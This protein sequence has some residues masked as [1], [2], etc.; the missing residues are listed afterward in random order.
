MKQPRKPPSRKRMLAKRDA[1]HARAYARHARLIAALHRI[2]AKRNLIIWI[3]QSDGTDAIVDV[4]DVS[5]NGMC[6]Q[7]EADPTFTLEYAAILK[8]QGQ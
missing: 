6:V 1:M 2:I 8:E 3:R 7:I 4:V 5:V